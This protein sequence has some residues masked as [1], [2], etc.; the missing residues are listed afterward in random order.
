M[1]F[2]SSG[3]RQQ[4]LPQIGL[5]VVESA[6]Q[7]VRLVR[8]SDTTLTTDAARALV[9]ARWGSQRTDRLVREIAER[10]ADLGP[11]HVATLR[12]LVE[13]AEHEMEEAR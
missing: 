3:V 4:N 10:R 6:G 7:V 12:A 1:I 2:C 8:M 11:G 5:H 9:R 13:D